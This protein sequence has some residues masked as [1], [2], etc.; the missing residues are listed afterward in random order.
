MTIMLIN[1]GLALFAML[2]IVAIWAAV[3]L[4]ARG[5]FGDRKLG[6]RGPVVDAKGTA[7]CCKNDGRLCEEHADGPHRTLN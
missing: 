3:H 4:L 1:F 7:W 5:R 2:S 6:C